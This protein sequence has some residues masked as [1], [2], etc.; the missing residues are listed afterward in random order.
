M[1]A[2]KGSLEPTFNEVKNQGPPQV[3]TTNST[4]GVI[5]LG[6]TFTNYVDITS[7]YP[8]YEYT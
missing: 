4:Y 5:Y 7:L 1:N 3:L 6:S 8:G 2:L